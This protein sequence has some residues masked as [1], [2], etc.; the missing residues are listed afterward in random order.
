M[1][2]CP[3]PFTLFPL[4][5]VELASCQWLRN[6]P[7]VEL[8]SCQWPEFKMGRTGIKPRDNYPEPCL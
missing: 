6:I 2:F 7:C 8:A 5:P 1:P 3:L 4:P